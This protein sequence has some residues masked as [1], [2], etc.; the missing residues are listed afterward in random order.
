[1][2]GSESFPALPPAQPSRERH[3]GDRLRARLDE[4]P[5][6]SAETCLRLY[7][8]SEASRLLLDAIGRHRG[9]LD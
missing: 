4:A 9:P 3:A 1:M 7:R 8:R 6:Q 5:D 2:R